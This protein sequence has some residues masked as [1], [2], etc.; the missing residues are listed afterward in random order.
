MPTLVEVRGDPLGSADPVGKWSVGDV[1]VHK[2]KDHVRIAI[3]VRRLD[4][5]V[6]R[7]SL[8]S[9]LHDRRANAE[10]NVPFIEAGGDQDV[11]CI[12][13]RRRKTDVLEGQDLECWRLRV[14]LG[15][16]RNRIRGM[17]L[18]WVH[19]PSLGHSSL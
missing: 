4:E 17:L 15:G 19:V 8:R 10:F 12:T 6:S 3:A 9:D 13:L 7:I 16:G 5:L 11:S 14:W 1:L 2:Q 18:P